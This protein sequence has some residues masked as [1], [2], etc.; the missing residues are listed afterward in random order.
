MFIFTTLAWRRL[1]GQKCCR[2]TDGNLKGKTEYFENYQQNILQTINKIFCKLSTKYFANYQQHF[3]QTSAN[4][5][6]ELPKCSQKYKKNP[7]LSV[8]RKSIH[9]YIAPAFVRKVSTL[10]GLIMEHLFQWSKAKGN[11]IRGRL[12]TCLMVWD[13]AS[14]WS[15]QWG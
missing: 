12:S 14:D 9:I 13:A 2:G 6:F 7:V 1:L 4:L 10:E 15:T 5:W 11:R 8:Q 3:Q